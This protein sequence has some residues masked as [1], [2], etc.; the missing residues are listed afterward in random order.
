MFIIIIIIIIIKMQTKI[1][2]GRRGEGE[3]I[4]KAMLSPPE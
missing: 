2:G 1:P 4:S 3:L